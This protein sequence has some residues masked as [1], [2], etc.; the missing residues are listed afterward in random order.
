[1]I[2]VYTTEHIP[3]KFNKSLFLAG[4]TPRSKD[5]ASWRPEALAVLESRGYDGV[6][7]IPEFRDQHK[8]VHS[9]EMIAWEQE[10]MNMSDCILF[11]IPRN[12]AFMPG[13]TTNHEH[14]EYFKTGR[15]VLGAPEWACHVE[16]LKFKAQQEN[17]P[18]T[19][20]LEE[21]IDST[22]KFIGE[23]EMRERGDRCVPLFIRRTVHFKNWRNNISEAGNRLEHATLKYSHRVNGYPLIWILQ[24]KIFITEEN[25]VKENEI[26]ISRPSISGTVLYKR[27]KSFL[28]TK[29]V[30]VKEF[31]SP[32][33]NDLGY[34]HEIVGG[35]TVKSG[36]TYQELA[37][38]EIREEIGLDIDSDRIN[39]VN[40][41]QVIPTLS[42]H[43]AF[44]A[45][46]ELNDEEFATLK[47][48]KISKE[49]FGC[50][51]DTE[52]TF[53]EILTLRKILEDNLVGWSDIGMIMEAM[54]KVFND[55]S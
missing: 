9:D 10:A 35:S 49:S 43:K 45:S 13:L 32:V 54:F 53:V 51:E 42:T 16:Y 2:K 38:D 23:G 52:R 29:I 40:I 26:V 33:N 20:N 17:I 44:V 48:R 15:V 24:P 55:M 31:R 34:V 5:A 1:M 30:L 22:I 47:Q 3:D 28:D 25:R 6:V 50:A 41:R 12:M 21:T 14:G 18:F 8:N 37:M 27:E 4:P 7:F 11:W 46:V 39:F 36:K 19:T